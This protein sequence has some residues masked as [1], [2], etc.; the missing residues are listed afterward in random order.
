MEIRYSNFIK[1]KDI[2]KHMFL[3]EC[4][5]NIKQLSNYN[6]N[7]IKNFFRK[8]IEDK[9]ENSYFRKLSMEILSFLTAIN[10]VRR[11]STLDILLDIEQDDSPVVILPTIKYLFSF[12]NYSED[13]AEIVN[14]IESF[15][16][17]DNGDISSEA[18]YR[19]GLINF[20]QNLSD[21]DVKDFYNKL[22]GSQSL[23]R[24]AYLL[25]ENRVDAKYFYEVSNFLIYIISGEREKIEKSLKKTLDLSFIRAAFSY[26]NRAIEL[27]SKIQDVLLNVYKIFDLSSKHEGWLDYL[28]EFT[29]LAQYYSEFLN[30]SLSNDTQQ[31]QLIN[32]FKGNIDK[33]ILED[34]YVR[35][36]ELY[37]AKIVNIQNSYPEDQVLNDFLSIVRTA[38]EQ[39][40]KKKSNNDLELIKTCAKI[41]RV[42]PHVNIDELAL[43]VQEIKNPNDVGE[44]LDIVK[45]YIE[46]QYEEIYDIYTGDVTGNEI[47]QEVISTIRSKI[48]TYNQKKLSEF[49]R[50]LEEIIKYLILTI[51][52]KRD[53]DFNLFY[54]EKHG[55]GG[56][57]VSER[58]FQN[59]LYRYLQRGNIAYGAQEEIEN[60]ANGGR[61]DIVFKLKDFVFPVELKKTNRPISQQSIR[62]KYL[63]Q[64][65]TYTYGYNQLGIF[66][67]LDLNEK[68]KPVNNVRE[69]VYVDN[70]APLYDLGNTY[71]DYIV[72]VIVPGNKY[73]P[74]DKSTYG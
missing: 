39:K 74:S 52:S 1:M 38:I 5:E 7:E 30:I 50:I 22:E 48:P 59:N 36:F 20:M 64:I 55:G 33:Y 67:V 61:V 71:P 32:N 35:N 72:V 47:F 18:Y 42:V 6:G 23:F 14:K 24:S 11:I 65:H 54:L 46:E 69:L 73:M 37:K 2:D 63:E 21:F 10:K 27:E 8:V 41:Q 28:G 53:T 70:L 62:D 44:I 68:D 60:F 56:S 45:S 51:K 58:E 66:V 13:D 49:K 15:K 16:D 31:V 40:N 57:R 17:F 26:N 43:K 9:D 3:E 34:L 29:K 12:Y 25:T 4:I 19:L